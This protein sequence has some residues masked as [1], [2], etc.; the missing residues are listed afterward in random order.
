MDIAA[1]QRVWKALSSV[2]HYLQYEFSEDL[3]RSS[4]V[5]PE[6]WRVIHQAAQ[7]LREE[8][9]NLP[10][11]LYKLGMVDA[12][13][14]SLQPNL[15]TLLD[16]LRE[17]LDARSINDLEMERELLEQANRQI[18]FAF[19]DFRNKLHDFKDMYD[20]LLEEDKDPSNYNVYFPSGVQIG[21]DMLFG[22][23]KVGGD[24]VGGDKVGGDKVGG[25]KVGGNK[26]ESYGVSVEEVFEQ[27]SAEISQVSASPEKEVAEL[28]AKNLEAEAKKGE[29]ADEKT[30]ERWLTTMLTMLPDVAEV[31]I[32]TFINPVQ[33]LSTV[34]QKVAQR[35]KA[36]RQV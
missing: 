12:L 5:R 8:R 34:F 17:L 26:V 30:V 35:A 16:T 1:A 25:D 22:S 31:A 4:T 6:D 2:D 14:N 23:E 9:L 18:N 27:L 29:D 33:G 36:S 7:V 13:Q 20:Q 3:N 32:N 11:E 15:N 28:A 21:G 10:K 19:A 24:K